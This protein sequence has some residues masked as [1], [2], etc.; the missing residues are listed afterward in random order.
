MIVHLEADL[1]CI[2]EA[3]SSLNVCNFSQENK[4]QETEP[5]KT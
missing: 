2:A 3:K 1:L 4:R 5:D